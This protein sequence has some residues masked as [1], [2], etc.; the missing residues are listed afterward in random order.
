MEDQVE[1][2]LDDDLHSVKIADA[3]ESA[4]PCRET[5]RKN[6]RYCRQ[7]E[8]TEKNTQCWIQIIF[9]HNFDAKKVQ[10]LESKKSIQ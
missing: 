6:G 2:Y 5:P 7:F 10:Y 3:P 9:L 1:K 8:V 4:P